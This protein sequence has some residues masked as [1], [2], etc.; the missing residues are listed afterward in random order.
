MTRLT[1]GLAG[2]VLAT[3]ATLA[4]CAT[5]NPRVG[6]TPG[7]ESS[8]PSLSG[9][10]VIDDAPA[11]LEDGRHPVYLKTVDVSGAQITFDLIRFL[12]GAEAKAEWLKQ[13]PSEP[14]GPPN[15]YL[16]VNVNPKLRTLPVAAGVSITVVDL[17]N[18]GLSMVTIAFADLLGHVAAAGGAFPFWLTVTGG[19]ITKIEE[20]FLP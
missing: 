3:L 17:T 7:G 8:S 11:V 4:G 13:H 15:D 5:P 10:Q 1:A 2:L 20:Q 14:D 9:T 18:P 12:T 19:Q 16:I 6:L